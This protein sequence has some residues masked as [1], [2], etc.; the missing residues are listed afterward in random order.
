MAKFVLF[1]IYECFSTEG[2]GDLEKDFIQ[3]HDTFEALKEQ[4]VML[5]KL[6]NDD[7]EPEFNSEGLPMG[8]VHDVVEDETGIKMQEF[9][10]EQQ[11]RYFDFDEN[12]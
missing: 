12:I 2:P 1:H 6:Y 5:Y 11:D 9:Y 8:Y 3:V 10:D 4:A 7:K